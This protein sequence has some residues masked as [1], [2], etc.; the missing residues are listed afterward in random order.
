[1][2]LEQ[3]N[4]FYCIYYLQEDVRRIELAVQMQLND[5]RSWMELQFDKLNRKIDNI[6]QDVKSR[7]KSKK[8]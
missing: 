3:D 6:A 8:V 1:M 4:N 7:K 2:Y 5:L